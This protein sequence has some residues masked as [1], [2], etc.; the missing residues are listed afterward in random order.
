MTSIGRGGPLG[1]GIACDDS[2]IARNLW[3]PVDLELRMSA[4]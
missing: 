2:G 1:D 4:W 3:V